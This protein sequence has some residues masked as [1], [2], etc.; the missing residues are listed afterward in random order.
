VARASE[1][2]FQAKFFTFG[3]TLA[4]QIFLQHMSSPPGYALDE[5]KL[6]CAGSSETPSLYAEL[7]EKT[8]LFSNIHAITSS[9]PLLEGLMARIASA[10]TGRKVERTIAS[11]QVLFPSRSLE[12]QRIRLLLLDDRTLPYEILGIQLSLH[13]LIFVPFPTLH[14]RPF[15]EARAHG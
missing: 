13:T 6:V 7:A 14:T 15:S 9:V 8:P 1:A 4:L 5:A 2:A 12:T 11:F 3:G 10:S